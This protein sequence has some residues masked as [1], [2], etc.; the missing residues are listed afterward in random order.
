MLFSMVKCRSLMLMELGGQLLGR[1]TVPTS[2]VLLNLQTYTYTIRPLRDNGNMSGQPNSSA[3]SSGH[4]LTGAGTGL[5]SSAGKG[6][7][8][9][10]LLDSNQG[11]VHSFEV[12]LVM[13]FW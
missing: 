3:H 1:F 4:S 12:R 11:A 13:E 6:H 10:K 8:P 9:D 2:H 5:T 7:N